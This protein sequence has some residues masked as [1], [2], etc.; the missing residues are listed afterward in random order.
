MP[1]AC[2]AHSTIF[3]SPKRSKDY[4][5]AM[6]SGWIE[7]LNL[8][9]LSMFTIC[10]VH[11]YN[12]F[13]LNGNISCKTISGK[14]IALEH[15]DF[16]QPSNKQIKPAVQVGAVHPI[17]LIRLDVCF[18]FFT[19]ICFPSPHLSVSLMCLQTVPYSNRD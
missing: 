15:F 12:L 8:V 7:E 14:A 9:F 10:S 4:V 18:F 19:L 13:F 6:I 2:W 1:S 16:Q 3:H 17:W 5:L 11:E